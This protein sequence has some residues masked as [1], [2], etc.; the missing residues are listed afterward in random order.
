[1]KSNKCAIEFRGTR[2]K[3]ITRRDCEDIK[4]IT[5]HAHEWRRN[6]SSEWII[7][8]HDLWMLVHT[9]ARYLFFSLS[10]LI[11]FLTCTC[12]RLGWIAAGAYRGWD[13]FTS[14][15]GQAADGKKKGH[16]KHFQVLLNRNYLNI[17]VY[18]QYWKFSI[19]MKLNR[20][21]VV[22]FHYSLANFAKIKRFQIF[23]K[24]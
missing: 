12:A 2:K 9:C 13:N 16:K 15:R 5:Q 6:E 23:S 22:T 4:T 14:R 11:Q 19:Q 7:L 17:Q 24:C 3:D 10:T 21:L 1:M 8:T 18:F 20:N